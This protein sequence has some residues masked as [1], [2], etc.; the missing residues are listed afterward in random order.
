MIKDMNGE[1]R[2]GKLARKQRIA[3]NEKRDKGRCLVSR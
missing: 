2:R 1:K 3:K